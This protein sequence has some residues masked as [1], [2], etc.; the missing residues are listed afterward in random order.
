[1]EPHRKNSNI[2]PVGKAA[3]SELPLSKPPTKK[4]TQRNPWLEP[5]K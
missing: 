1:M 5:C 4:Y 3:I 2:N